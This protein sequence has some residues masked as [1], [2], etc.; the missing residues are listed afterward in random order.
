MPVTF[1]AAA[2]APES[3]ESAVTQRTVTI[4]TVQTGD[5]LILHGVSLSGSAV[6]SLTGT[7]ASFTK[8][9]DNARAGVTS[10]LWWKV[11]AAADS[12]K[13]V[14]VNGGT[15]NPGVAGV[16]A[17]RGATGVG[18]VTNTNQGSGSNTITFPAFTPSPNQVPLQVMAIATSSAP[19]AP[20]LTPPSGITVTSSY[21][22]TGTEP[23]KRAG[24]ITG[25]NLTPNSAVGNVWDNTGT[26]YAAT[27]LVP[28]TVV[29]ESLA[30]PT[31][32][33]TSTNP[34]TI[35]ASDGAADASWT[36]SAGAVAY[37]SCIL[38]GHVTT[39]ASSTR[40]D[41]TR[42]RTFTGLA[43]GNYTVAV[44]AV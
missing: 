33:V 29:D 16:S 23:N 7:L 15:A 4:P 24:L 2:Y 12:G 18:A 6:H 38:P 43:A 20:G 32:S 19:W 10:T 25:A 41:A 39:G 36:A 3:T 21:L 35:G 1:V 5:I 22:P 17:Y 30:A 27:W 8:I 9:G 11:A 31:I 42:A 40:S 44:R 37:E 13:T 26:H 14:I 28:L 34:T